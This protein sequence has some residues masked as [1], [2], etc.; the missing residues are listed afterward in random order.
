MKLRGPAI[1]VH[2]L[3]IVLVIGLL[4]SQNPDSRLGLAV[5]LTITLAGLLTLLIKEEWDGT[6]WVSLGQLFIIGLFLIIFLAVPHTGV[7]LL[8]GAVLVLSAFVLLIMEAVAGWRSYTFLDKLTNGT[9]QKT[10][11]LQ[12]VE[13]TEKLFARGGGDTYHLESCRTLG[14]TKIADLIHLN[15]HEEAKNYGLHPCKICKP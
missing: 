9:P 14:N 6:H 5:L 7:T 13:P 10:Q 2:A 12:E 3:T 4:F 11:V 1:L 15:S 8:L